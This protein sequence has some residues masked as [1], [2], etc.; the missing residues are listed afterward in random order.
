[1]REDR[2]LVM[3]E[4]VEPMVGRWRLRSIQPSRNSAP[5]TAVDSVER[6][7]A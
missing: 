4:D 1:M 5:L 2:E 7:S 3:H 6:P